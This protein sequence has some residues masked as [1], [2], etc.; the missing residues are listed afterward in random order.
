[1]HSLP[2]NISYLRSSVGTNINHLLAPAAVIFGEQDS[3]IYDLWGFKSFG[4]LLD[5]NLCEKD[6]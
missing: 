6:H 4:Y 5:S 1:M 2:T 3:I